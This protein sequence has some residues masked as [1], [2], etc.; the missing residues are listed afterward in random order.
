GFRTP[1]PNAGIFEAEF[2]AFK[3]GEPVYSE[4]YQRHDAIHNQLPLPQQSN[5]PSSQAI[6][7]ALDFQNLHVHDARAGPLPSSEFRSEAPLQRHSSSPWQQEFLQQNKSPS[8]NH[9]QLNLPTGYTPYATSAQYPTYGNSYHDPLLKQQPES[10][11]NDSFDEE[12]FERAFNAARME[13]QDQEASL[14][15]EDIE[16]KPQPAETALEHEERIDYRIGSDI[17][18]DEASQRKGETSNEQDADELARTAGQLLENV[19]HDQ[20]AK[21]Q[22][23]NFLSLMRQL[24]DKEVKVEGDSIVDI[25]QPLHPGG[26]G[27]PDGSFD[28]VE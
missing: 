2:E 27:Y 24:R 12:A 26:Q 17:I 4:A 18:S 9:Q 22:Q 25:E 10:Q 21:F 15:Q 14:R 28:L 23:S 1:K 6:D 19:K 11:V 20:S 16:K 5:I 3:A 8:Y 7:W 13:V